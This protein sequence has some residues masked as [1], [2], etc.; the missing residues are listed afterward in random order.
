MT[1]RTIILPE[2]AQPEVAIWQ[3][4][5]AG[6]LK[7][8]VP[9]PKLIDLFCGAGGMTL[10]FTEALGHAFEPV[11]ANDVDRSA[12]ETYNTNFGS[13][14]QVGEVSACGNRTIFTECMI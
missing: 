10:G 11:W 3:R 7:R 14:C 8:I 1:D 6:R 2:S 12:V 5:L 4:R 9:R 13:H